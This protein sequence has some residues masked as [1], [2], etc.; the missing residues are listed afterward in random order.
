MKCNNKGQLQK[1]SMVFISHATA[2]GF[3][4]MHPSLIL[5]THLEGWCSCLRLGTGQMAGCLQPHPQH[6][7]SLD[8]FLNCQLVLEASSSPRNQEASQERVARDGGKAKKETR[9]FR[10]PDPEAPDGPPAVQAQLHHKGGRSAPDPEAMP[11]ESQWFRPHTCSAAD[12][13][14]CPTLC[15][16]GAT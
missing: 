10:N 3:S 12:A 7:W 5:Q 4:P 6:Q 15:Q 11:P 16:P 13:A 2:A 8:A 9:L 14:T 1:K